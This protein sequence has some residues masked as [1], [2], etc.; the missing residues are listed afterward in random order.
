MRRERAKK[1]GKV[2]TIVEIMRRS[3]NK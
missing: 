3:D 2:R 1:S